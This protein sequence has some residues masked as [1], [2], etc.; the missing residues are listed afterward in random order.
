MSLSIEKIVV[1]ALTRTLGA[2]SG[3]LKKGEDHAQQKGFDPLILVNAR[4]SPDM[5]PLKRQVQMTTDTARRVL[6]QL[7][8]MDIPSVADTEETFA[9]LQARVQSTLDFVEAFDKSKLKGAEDRIV[10]LPIGENGLDLDAMSFLMGFALPNFY[11]HAAATYNILRHNGVAVGKMDFL[12][13]P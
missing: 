7:G 10:T 4:L 8:E 13:A 5:H 6:C 2:M 11:F 3:I 9:E 1:P 12:G